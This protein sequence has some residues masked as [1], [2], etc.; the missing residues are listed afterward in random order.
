[1]EAGDILHDIMGGNGPPLPQL[2]APNE[3]RHESL[4]RRSK[5]VFVYSSDEEGDVDNS[6]KTRGVGVAKVTEVL[7]LNL[8]PNDLR[9]MR[10]EA[11]L[12]AQHHP[13]TALQSPGDTE[14]QPLLFTEDT[15]GENVPFAVQGRVKV[16]DA[17]PLRER[18]SSFGNKEVPLRRHLHAEETKRLAYARK[19]FRDDGDNE[20]R[21]S[22]E[23]AGQCGAAS[24]NVVV[25]E[26]RPVFDGEGL[27]RAIAVGGYQLTVDEHELQVSGV[28]EDVVTGEVDIGHDTLEDDYFDQEDDDEEEEDEELEE[29]VVVAVVEQLVRCCEVGELDESLR[30][31]GERFLVKAR[32]CLQRLQTGELDM[33][34]FGDELQGDILR[35]SRAFQRFRRPKDAPVVIDGVVMDM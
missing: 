35:L 22:V 15:T 5:L 30:G 17:L 21:S 10:L 11:E 33:A 12:A 9:E 29:A 31:A 14:Q 13:H 6:E 8:P 25:A 34:A 3:Q 20:E 23:D 2:Q 26:P 18:S 1:M 4:P 16:V 19:R 27:V 7:T 24:G 32:S 28:G